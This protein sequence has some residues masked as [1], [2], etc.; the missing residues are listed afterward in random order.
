MGAGGAADLASKAWRAQAPLN[1]PTWG[2]AR[3]AFADGPIDT[4]GPREGHRWMKICWFKRVGFLGPASRIDEPK[5]P[6]SGFRA[7]RS[8]MLRSPRQ[9]SVKRGRIGCRIVE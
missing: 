8:I 1:P 2:I 3:T 5:R 4:K 9:S 6:E 7:T